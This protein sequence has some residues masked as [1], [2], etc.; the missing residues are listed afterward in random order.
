VARVQ[1]KYKKK[2]NQ[3]HAQAYDAMYI[4][5][6]AIKQAGVTDS[7]PENR[8]KIRDALARITNF[9]GVSGAHSFKPGK[10]DAEKSV[11]VLTLRDGKYALLD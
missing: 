4:L 5:A 9:P 11:F 7:T 1:E 3:F 6:E 10:G 8:A 2:P